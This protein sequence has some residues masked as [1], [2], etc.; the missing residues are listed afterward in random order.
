[1]NSSENRNM[2]KWAEDRGVVHLNVTS[3]CDHIQPKTFSPDEEPF[4]RITHILKNT[5]DL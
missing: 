3:R 2:L 1:M 5:T 4:K